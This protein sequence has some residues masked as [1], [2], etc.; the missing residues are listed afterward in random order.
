MT[1]RGRG[2]RGGE[3]D[4]QRQRRTTPERSS[5]GGPR[6]VRS[7]RADAPG[8]D[9]HAADTPPVRKRW[10]P[11]GD[12]P[13]WVQEEVSRV[14]A[15]GRIPATLELLQVAAKEFAAAKFGKA[16]R[17]LEEAKELS[18]RTATIREMLGLSAYRLGRWEQALREL[19][20][21]RR[22]TGETT[23]MP[24][25]MDVLRALDRPRD[26]EEVWKAFRR[27]GGERE[28]EREARVVFGAF[29]LDNGRER[30]AWEITNPKR[31]GDKPHE[32][33]LRVWFVAARAAAR[34]GDL[35]TGRRLYEAIQASDAGFPGLDE[36]DRAT[37][38]R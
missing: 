12:L 9:R 37:A 21:F 22:L 33:E 36:L 18:P 11:D 2:D 19:R 8:R 28:V 6:L 23:H 7:T 34:L 13:K 38:G 10:S 26:V 24:V 14:T 29:L 31:I 17:D 5:S 25:E 32:S 30:E 27:I 35:K 4:R 16:L 15:K 3:G 1:T 20:T